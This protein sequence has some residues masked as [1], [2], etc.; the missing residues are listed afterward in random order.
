MHIR[1]AARLGSRNHA[2]QVASSSA[3]IHKTSSQADEG[4]TAHEA[5]VGQADAEAEAAKAACSSSQADEAEVAQKPQ[6]HTEL[7]VPSPSDSL[8]SINQARNNNNG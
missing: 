1:A 3:S 6:P 2:L 4:D 5:C 7:S 8:I